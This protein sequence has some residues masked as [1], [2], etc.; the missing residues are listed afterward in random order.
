M[1]E[2]FKV[3]RQALSGLKVVGFVTAGVGP[4]ILRSLATNGAIVVRVESMKNPD[5]TRT[6]SPYK[7]NKPGVN[8]SYA[9]AHT[10]PGNFGIAINLKHPRSTEVARRLVSWADVIVENWRPGVM[11]SWNLGYEQIRA[12]NPDIIMLSSSQ[13]GET[14]PHSMIAATGNH[15]SGLIGFVVLTGWPDRPPVSVGPYPDYIAP[16]FGTTIILAA[17]DYRRR[18]GKGQHIDLSQYETSIHYLVPAIL[19]YTVNNRVQTRNGNSCPYAA[20]YGVYR[21]KGDDK[22][23]AIAVFRE[24]EWQAFCNVIGNPDWTQDIKFKTL[25][26]RK[27]H[28]DEL[29]NLVENWTVRHTAE[30]VMMMMQQVGV[31]AGVVRD[32]GEV[33]ENCP[34]S[35]YRHYFWSIEHPEIG[36]HTLYG[37]SYILSK[38]PYHIQKPAPIIGQDNEYI[39]TQFLGMSDQE[40]LELLQDNVFE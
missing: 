36:T 14:G 17:L 12:I 1:A 30:E 29:N 38:T 18:T 9:F 40:F 34:Q 8:R 27:D 11:E 25:A 28:E 31:E 3:E 23:C 4:L 22:W 33:I 5:V 10:S 35:N 39:C 20:P 21:C 13:Q 16:L 24:L 26:S 6:M 32:M 2:T 37:N 15:L 7:D 19:D